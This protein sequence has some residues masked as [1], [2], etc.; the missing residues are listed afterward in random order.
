MEG[1]RISDTFNG[2]TDSVIT[3]A[4]SPIIQFPIQFFFEIVYGRISADGKTNAKLFENIGLTGFTGDSFPCRSIP[5]FKDTI[6]HDYG[7]RSCRKSFFDYINQFATRRRGCV[8]DHIHTPI[9]IL[10]HLRR[11][12][13]SKCNRIFLTDFPQRNIRIY[14]NFHCSLR[15]CQQAHT[16]K[17][18]CNHSQQTEPEAGF[19]VIQDGF[20]AVFDTDLTK[21]Y[22][23]G[24]I[25]RFRGAA[26]K[27]SRRICFP[28][29]QFHKLNDT[30]IAGHFNILAKQYVADPD[31]RIK[32]VYSKGNETDH[33]D[34]MIS[35]VQMRM[36]MGKNLLPGLRGHACG[37]VDSGFDEA[38][39]KSSFDSSRFPTARDLHGIKH[40]P[41]KMN[42]RADAI[43]TDSG[44][45]C[46][47][48]NRENSS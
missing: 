13:R 30:L 9:R 14:R 38:Q 33:L 25:M 21:G 2:L 6:F 31:Q 28:L 48:D 27:Q 5:F 20:D 23:T 17:S 47:P 40:L 46:N 22:R 4:Q 12:S 26:A 8:D 35:L 24:C 32:P 11:C 10:L 41:A 34:P 29:V 36:F 19:P 3:F 45:Q 7:F 16:N 1:C 15:A 39:D 18:K 37:N 42:I 43:G 44:C